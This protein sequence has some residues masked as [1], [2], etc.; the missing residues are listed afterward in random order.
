MTI[1]VAVKVQDCIVF[2]ADS[3]SSLQTVLAD[4]SPITINTY[5]HANKVFNV[6]KGLPIA[7]MTAGIGNF[8]PASI[9][10]IT[11]DFRALLSQAG[12]PYY[13]DPHNYTIEQVVTLARQYFFIDRFQKLDP[14]PSGT[15]Q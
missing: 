14:A 15:F 5:D 12:G 1:C 7:A 2:A 6:R 3:T 10:T 11:K 13:I 9:S 8:G 4:G